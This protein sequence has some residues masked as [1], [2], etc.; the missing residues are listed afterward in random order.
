MKA[1]SSIHCRGMMIT[2]GG[3]RIARGCNRLVHGLTK[4]TLI[5]YFSGMKIDPK[6]TPIECEP[7][8]SHR[9]TQ[10]LTE[11]VCTHVFT[12]GVYYNCHNLTVLSLP[13]KKP[14]VSRYE[15]IIDCFFTS[16]WSLASS[17][18][19]TKGDFHYI[20]VL[21]KIKMCDRGCFSQMG[22]VLFV[23]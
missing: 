13:V 20:L 14:F 3:T 18:N 22:D 1:F 11:L 8:S 5:T 15:W 2:R 6:Y 12:T 21:K 10:T 4:S 7:V 17:V 23:H 19:N 9:L 16:N